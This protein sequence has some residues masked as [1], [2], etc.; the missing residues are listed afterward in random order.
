VRQP[1]IDPDVFGDNAF[2]KVVA[3]GFVFNFCLYGSIFCLAVGLGRLRGLDAPA[4]D[5][6]R[7]HPAATATCGLLRLAEARRSHSLDIVPNRRRAWKTSSSGA[8]TFDDRRPSSRKER[9]RL[10]R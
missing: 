7:R 6:D 4:T 8:T 3:I 1:L 9:A 10:R 5:D 2:T